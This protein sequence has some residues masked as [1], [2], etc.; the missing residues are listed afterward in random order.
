MTQRIDIKKFKP[1]NMKEGNVSVFIGKRNTGKSFLIKDVLSYHKD[2][3]PAGKVIAATDH[4]NH[5]YDSFIPGMLVHATYTENIINDLFRRQNVAIQQ[6]WDRPG[7][8]VVLDDCL[9]DK[10]WQ[11]SKCIRQIFL[12]GRHS[13]ITL[14]L[15]IQGPMEIPPIFRAQTDYVFILR[16]NLIRDK[17]SL[18]ENYAGMVEYAVFE[19]LMNIFTED[20]GVLVIDNTTKSN[21]IEDQIFYYKAEPHPNLRL[22]DDRL[23]RENQANYVQKQQLAENSQDFT[24]RNGTKYTVNRN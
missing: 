15:G 19:H 6:K 14:L 22:C 10:G 9:S 2:K 13:K 1:E 17:K 24:L 4:L 18:H 5:F 3:F 20:H 8:F 21:K 11:K 16:N 23:W 12:E 7:V